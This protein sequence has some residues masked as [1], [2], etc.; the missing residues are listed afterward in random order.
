MASKGNTRHI[1][2]LAS[3][4]YMKIERKSSKYVAKPM[5]GRH[6]SKSNIALTTVLKEKMMDATSRDVR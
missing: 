5:A 3:T 2:R 6:N 4:R 1:R